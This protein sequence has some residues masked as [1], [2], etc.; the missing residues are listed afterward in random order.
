MGQKADH[1]EQ[2]YR[3]SGD[4]TWGRR[5]TTEQ[6]GRGRRR[7][8]EEMDR[9]GGREGGR[10]GD[11]EEAAE[12]AEKL[13]SDQVDKLC[14]EKVYPSND[15]KKNCLVQLRQSVK[16]FKQIAVSSLMIF[17]SLCFSKFNTARK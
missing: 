1:R 16:I 12:G 7:G 9:E 8:A 10:G 6:R 5:S 13:V 4:V 2:I 14:D 17:P 15:E 11:T 3:K